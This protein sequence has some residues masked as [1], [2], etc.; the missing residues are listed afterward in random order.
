MFTKISIVI[1]QH[2]C[3]NTSSFRFT[4]KLVSYIV[5][6]RIPFYFVKVFT[7]DVVV[8]VG[9]VLSRQAVF[10]F[11]EHSHIIAPYILVL[12]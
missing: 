12:R 11:H 8:N 5:T 9:N 6:S 7:I 10:L 3:K 4:L 2:D 1:R